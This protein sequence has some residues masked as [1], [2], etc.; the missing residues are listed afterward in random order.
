MKHIVI[1]AT[2]ALMGCAATNK[3]LELCYGRADGQ[4]AIDLARQ[5]PGAGECAEDARLEQEHWSAYESCL[6]ADAERSGQ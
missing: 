6:A 5:C 4:Y 1:I 3:Q 2:L